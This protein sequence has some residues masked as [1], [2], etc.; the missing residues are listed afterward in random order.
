MTLPNLWLI[1]PEQLQRIEQA[2]A[3]VPL[4]FGDPEKLAQVRSAAVAQRA[5]NSR[6]LAVT[7]GEAQIRVSGPLL[8]GPDWILDWFEIEYTTYGDLRADLAEASNDKGVT[9]I[10]LVLD[11]PGGMVSGLFELLAE[12]QRFSK[13][14]RSTASLAASAAYAIAAHGGKIAATDP[15]A[16][17]GSIGVAASYWPSSMIDVTSTAAP[18]KRPDPKTEQGRSVIRAY[19]DEIHEL[20]ASSIAAGRGTTAASVNAEYGGGRVFL[21]AESLRRSMIDSIA[22][23]AG[24]KTAA[25]AATKGNKMNLD[26][27]KAEHPALFAQVHSLGEAAGVTAERARVA[28]HLQLG[29]DCGDVTVAFAPI[30]EGKS[31]AQAQAAY[32]GANMRRNAQQARQDDDTTVAGALGGRKPETEGAAKDQAF[33]KAFNAEMGH[34]DA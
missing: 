20:F 10:E 22:G 18:D 9:G 23:D 12:L 3:R 19:L 7:N 32:L 17:F 27:L 4:L 13:A 16:T 14:K 11:S 15:L 2:H 24:E 21:A 25:R 28:D 8:D 6:K 26:Q 30:R 33:I 31:V 1:V 5:G 29:Q 34:V